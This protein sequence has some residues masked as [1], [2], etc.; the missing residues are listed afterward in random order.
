M[1]IGSGVAWCHLATNYYLSRCWST[2][3]SPYGIT[4]SQWVNSLWPSDA[5]WWHGSGSTLAQVMA[6]C[7]TAPSHY[8]N[9]CWLTISEI[10]WHSPE[11][12]FT[13]NTKDIYLWNEFEIYKF[14]IVVKS[15]RGQW[16]KWEK[17]KTMT[18]DEIFSTTSNQH[19]KVAL[20]VKKFQGY[21]SQTFHQNLQVTWM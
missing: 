3:M 14:Y 21:L 20:N 16:V 19:F 11:S 13:E 12:N 17:Q 1:N 6:C 9:Q 8:L 18:R 4:S 15:A 7:L 5:I 10:L 2:S